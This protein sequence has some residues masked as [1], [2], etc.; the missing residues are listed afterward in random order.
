MTVQAN[1]VEI[2]ALVGDASRAAMMSALMSGQSLTGRELAEAAH[3]TKSTAS[4]HLS[5]LVAARLVTASEGGRHRYYRIASKLVA[6]MIESIGAVAAFETPARY[7]PRG[8]LSAEQRTLRMCYDHLAGAV[9][10]AIADTLIRRGHIRMDEDGGVVTTSGA[11]FL[12]DFGVDIDD[13]GRQARRPF[14]RPCLDWTERRVHLAGRLGA[15]IA[16][17]CFTRGWIERESARRA[18]RVTSRGRRGL[19]ET[20]AISCELCEQ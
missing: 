7:Q 20:F 12:L 16:C 13:G 6:E 18:V 15:A 3:V 9:G 19:A 17:Q 14:C 1:M 4:E 5:R 10:V 8:A 2:A 11:R